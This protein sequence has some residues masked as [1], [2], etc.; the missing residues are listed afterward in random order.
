MAYNQW[1]KKACM[2]LSSM[3]RFSSKKY[4]GKICK[5]TGAASCLSKVGF[6]L[7]H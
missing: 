2:R 4:V 3:V 7:V 1:E 5:L 6:F